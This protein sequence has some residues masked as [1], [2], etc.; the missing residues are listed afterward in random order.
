MRSKFQSIVALFTEKADIQIEC[1]ED[2][3]VLLYCTSV[4]FDKY[5]SAQVLSHNLPNISS[6]DSWR[7]IISSVNGERLM[8]INSN[9]GNIEDEI[10]LKFKVKKLYQNKI[11]NQLK[12]D[13]LTNEN[14][15][16]VNITPIEDIE[17]KAG[18]I[19]WKKRRAE[20][21]KIVDKFM[22]ENK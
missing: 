13:I 21:F 9:G 18:S 1:K 11:I 17:Y 6:R 22:E 15:E 5:P 20:L 3:E 4:S 7:L 19:N 14:N 2:W 8:D 12:R 10:D 16:I